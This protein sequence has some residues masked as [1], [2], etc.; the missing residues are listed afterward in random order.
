MHAGL[1]DH[2]EHDIFNRFGIDG[3]IDAGAAIDDRAVEL[4]QAP[5]QFFAN[6]LAD[7]FAAPDDM[8]GDQEHQPAGPQAAEMAVAFD[9]GHIG[10]RPFR[11]N[12]SGNPCRAGP[13]HENIGRVQN[14]EFPAEAAKLFR[15]SPWG[16]GG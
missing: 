13:Q 4:V 5:Q 9:E 15:W 14:G 6:S 3:R 10:S 12:R 7:L 2:F 16:I 8:A 1:F 11:G